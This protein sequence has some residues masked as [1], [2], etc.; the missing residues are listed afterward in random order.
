MPAFSQSIET[1]D[2]TA[3]VFPI[4][5]FFPQTVTKKESN[6]KIFNTKSTF[7]YNFIELVSAAK[8]F[9]LLVST[10]VKKNL[11]NNFSLR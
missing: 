9:S 10:I 4:C 6:L 5:S 8:G 3:M 2:K 11:N 1:F 7:S